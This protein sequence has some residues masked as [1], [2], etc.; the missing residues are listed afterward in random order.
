MLELHSIYHTHIQSDDTLILGI[1]G[2]VDSMVLLDILSQ[3]H[4][5]DKLIVV[6]FDHGLR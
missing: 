1:S 3:H 5:K 2:G 4:P 6:H